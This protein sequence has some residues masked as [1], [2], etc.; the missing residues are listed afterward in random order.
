M[1]LTFQKVSFYGLIKSESH[2][3]IEFFQKWRDLT[4]CKSNIVKSCHVEN[5][6][7]HSLLARFIIPSSH[8][9]PAENGSNIRLLNSI[10]SQGHFEVILRS[11]L[12]GHFTH[13]TAYALISDTKKMIKKTKL[14]MVSMIFIF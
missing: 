1:H 12:A 2:S 6:L 4:I 7:D 3:Y 8:S 10:L 5:F 11:S 9:K 13:L 14:L